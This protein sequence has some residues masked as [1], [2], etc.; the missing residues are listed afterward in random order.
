MILTADHEWPIFRSA[1]QSWLERGGLG[2]VNIWVPLVIVW[3]AIGV[4]TALLLVPQSPNQQRIAIF[5]WIVAGET[6]LLA[7]IIAV[8]DLVLI[9][10][11]QAPFTFDPPLKWWHILPFSAIVAG[12]IIGLNW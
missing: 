5:A 1:V 6:A 3:L 7:G 4:I 8:A 10:K 2:R 11:G 9:S 12:L